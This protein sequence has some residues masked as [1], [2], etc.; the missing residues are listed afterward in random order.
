[1]PFK[2]TIDD[3][4][5]L[6]FIK[7]GMSQK[8]AAERLG[9]SSAAV[10]KRLK[11]I[12]PAPDTILDKYNLTESQKSFVV[13]KAKGRTSTEAVLESYEVT[14]RQS[15][16]AIGSQNMAN[17]TIKMA[18]DELMDSH[19]LTKS[20]RVL[21]LKQ[22]VDNRDPNVSLKALDQTWKLDGSFKEQEDRLGNIYLITQHITEMRNQMR[23]YDETERTIEIEP[24][25]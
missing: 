12:L 13:E 20:Y 10:S 21:K 4:K 22:H 24:G 19:G 1:M 16:K 7:E 11:T 9:V 3:E 17:P 5:L 8:D 25:D 18:I 2:K 15:A 14:S 6:S 23:D